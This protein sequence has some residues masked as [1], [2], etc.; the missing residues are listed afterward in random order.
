MS[1]V[2]RETYLE[3]F[4]A[5]YVM[6]YKYKRNLTVFFAIL[7]IGFIEVSSLISHILQYIIVILIALLFPYMYVTFGLRSYEQLFLD[8]H[9]IWEKLRYRRR[10]DRIISQQRYVTVDFYFK[11]G[12]IFL[13]FL[14]LVLSITIKAYPVFSNF[15]GNYAFTADIA[16]FF[17]IWLMLSSLGFPEFQNDLFLKTYGHYEEVNNSKKRYMVG[18][19][20]LLF[21][22]F[23]L[24][25]LGAH[26]V[27]DYEVTSYTM[28]ALIFLI[29]LL[30]FDSFAVVSFST[31]RLVSVFYVSSLFLAY[32]A[33]LPIGVIYYLIIYLGHTVLDILVGI[34]A[35]IFIGSVNIAISLILYIARRDKYTSSV[36]LNA[37]V[38]YDQNSIIT[39]IVSNSEIVECFRRVLVPFTV[40]SFIVISIIGVLLIAGVS[41]LVYVDWLITFWKSILYILLFGFLSMMNAL[42]KI[43]RIYFGD[44]EKTF[45]ETKRIEQRKRKK[46]IKAKVEEQKRK[47]DKAEKMDVDDI[48]KILD[49]FES[50][51][52]GE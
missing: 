46:K 15:L 34:L 30:M 36:F 2:M 48:V 1:N 44:L 45:E 25:F 18:L 27:L 52:E 50:I 37:T 42:Y 51:F 6:D 40:A 21:F 32:L 4:K 9:I 39:S 49:E 17:G 29:I 8:F 19:S 26:G 47:S 7:I 35:L 10:S 38:S 41:V 43:G 11:K 13:G 12:N 31:R 16:M 28:T 14:L 5:N 22:A 33:M 3:D 23:I 24:Y 20:L